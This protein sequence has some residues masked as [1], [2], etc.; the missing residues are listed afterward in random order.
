MQHKCKLLVF[1]ISAKSVSTYPSPSPNWIEFLQNIP[2][3]SRIYHYV[4]WTSL[5]FLVNINIHDRDASTE[6][7][8]GGLLKLELKAKL[9]NWL[10][11]KVEKVKCRAADEKPVQKVGYNA[12]LEQNSSFLCSLKW[13]WAAVLCNLIC[14]VPKTNS[15]WGDASEHD[16]VTWES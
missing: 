6:R 14:F 11:K 3:K 8:W 16:L 15:L 7:G 4:M 5:S 10:L 2:E 1:F 12:V 9:N 13:S